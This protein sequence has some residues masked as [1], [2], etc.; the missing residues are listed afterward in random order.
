M[1]DVLEA[2]QM[3]TFDVPNGEYHHWKLSVDGRSRPLRWT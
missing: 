3:I 2:Q 1:P